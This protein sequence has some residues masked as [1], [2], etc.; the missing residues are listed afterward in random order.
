MWG[1][2]ISEQLRLGRLT[3]FEE[4]TKRDVLVD[5]FGLKADQKRG[6]V[7][8]S[9]VW[10][11]RSHPDPQNVKY[12]LMCEVLR[13]AQAGLLDFQMGF[14][15]ELTAGWSSLRAEDV[16]EMAREG[17]VWLDYQS[18]PQ[19]DPSAQQA[20]IE[21]LSLYV[22]HCTLFVALAP[23]A[24]HQET[25][26]L[27]DVRAW[28]E[29]G[30]CRAELLCNVLSD[31]PAPMVKV[32]SLVCRRI[33]TARDFVMH[34]V[35]RGRFTYETDRTR[36]S[37]MMNRL[38]GLR[39]S[40]LRKLDNSFA[41][42]WLL[43]FQARLLGDL[44][45]DTTED[46]EMAVWLECMRFSS[47]VEHAATGWTP[48]RYAVYA[49]RLDLARKMVEL[50][51]DVEAPL[52]RDCSRAAFFHGRGMTILQGA[53]MTCDS[54]EAV[55][56]LVEARAQ[57]NATWS[58]GSSALFAAAVGGR[59]D[60]LGAL[61]DARA[62]PLLRD[63]A[64]GNI[65]HVACAHGGARLLEVLRERCPQ[66]PKQL[67]EAEGIGFGYLAP[68][69][70][71]DRGGVEALQLALQLGADPNHRTTPR[72]A[73]LRALVR[74]SQATCFVSR[75]P[76]HLDSWAANAPGMTP[77]LWASH[78]GNLPAARLLLEQR[79]DAAAVNEYGRSALSL[80]AMNGHRALCECLLEAGVRAG[81]E[82]VWGR[83]AAAWAGLRGDPELERALST[84]GAGAGQAA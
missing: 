13:R 54:P 37:N 73:W 59:A 29:R 27:V 3:A 4:L 8:F 58:G 15:E 23:P 83:S 24:L 7:F 38:V 55:R 34:P 72:A 36:V 31:D 5:N 28:S 68:G 76:T 18:V 30:W 56:L 20:H 41:M 43:T 45:I 69:L 79:A 12:D 50:G 47:P 14:E 61:L 77:L 2:P 26:E 19:Q 84:A 82:D 10:L 60:N 17:H 66:L 33:S 74:K 11:G 64:G 57:V 44:S 63:G 39:L 52:A 25:R 35:G 71:L 78:F 51:A 75:T 46:S 42:R 67:A 9:H 53:A 40:V 62:D 6:V 48:L 21:C 65:L 81:S 32:E 16:Q 1:C 80:A 70:M 49:G 22:R